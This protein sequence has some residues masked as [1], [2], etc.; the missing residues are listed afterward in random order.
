MSS[1]SL[2]AGVI[3]MIV[4]SLSTLY[5]PEVLG[6]GP[7]Y[8]GII[9]DVALNQPWT[10]TGITVAAGQ[11]YRIIMTGIY[12]VGDSDWP[13]AMDLYHTPEGDGH[14]GGSYPDLSLHAVIA[15]IGDGDPFYI[16]VMRDFEADTSG[17]LKLG[18]NDTYYDDNDGTLTA[19]IWML[20]SLP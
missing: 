8:Q 13:C 2:S 3:M 11:S 4:L 9:I 6:Q 10:N 15:Q 18:I 19:Q 7:N 17:E 20:Q 12:E 14:N 5:A 1:R 16:G